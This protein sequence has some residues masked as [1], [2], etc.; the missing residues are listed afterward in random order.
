MIKITIA[1]IFKQL[2]LTLTTIVSLT[3]TLF[4][5]AFMWMSYLNLNYLSNEIDQSFKVVVNINPDLSKDK[6]VKEYEKIEAS[7]LKIPNVE[8]FKFSSKDEE[9]NIIRSTKMGEQLSENL[10]GENPLSDTYY[11]SVKDEKYL[12]NVALD[13]KNIKNV[14]SANY[15]GG[16]IYNLIKQLHASENIL[17]IIIATLIIIAILLMSNILR[18]AILHQKEAIEIMRLVGASNSYIRLPYILEGL[19]VTVIS[20]I[21]SSILFY[22]TQKIIYSGF[23][24]LSIGNIKLD[25]FNMVYITSLAISFGVGLLISLFASTITIRRFIKI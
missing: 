17:I 7:I 14:E 10:E 25:N 20:F 18:V 19:I 9:L 6:N 22:F 24:K 13:I 4:I 23:E 1:N 2:G 11:V 12:K 15:G 3:I 16:D 21:F 5:I 8:S